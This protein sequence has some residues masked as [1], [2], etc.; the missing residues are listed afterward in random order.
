MVIVQWFHT[1]AGAMEDYISSSTWQC[2]LFQ[3]FYI[4]IARDLQDDSPS[5]LGTI[6]H[7]KHI[8]SRISEARVFTRKNMR[9]KKARWMSIWDSL[10]EFL[11]FWSIYAMILVWTCLKYKL[12]SNIQDVMGCA[13]RQW[14]HRA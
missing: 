12:I 6:A 4:H 2:P 13:A 14:Y 3:F 8:F 7:M 5:V 1:V 9:V 10:A 11:P